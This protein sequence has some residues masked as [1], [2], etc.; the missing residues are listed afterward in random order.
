MISVLLFSKANCSYAVNGI[1]RVV[2]VWILFVVAVLLLSKPGT[3]AN[4]FAGI[5]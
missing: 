3:F 5:V 4:I 1:S 2:S